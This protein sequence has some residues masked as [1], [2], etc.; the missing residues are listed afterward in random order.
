MKRAAL[1]IVVAATFL[2]LA[3][4]SLD[5]FTIEE[6]AQTTVEGAGVLGSALGAVSFTGFTGL[7]L[8]A[9][10]TLQNQGV[11]EQDIDSVFVRSLTLTVVSPDDGDFD[12]L[13]SIEFFVEAEGLD[14]VAIASGSNFADG[15]RVIGLDVSGVDLAPYVAA[16]SLDITTDATGRPPVEDTTIDAQIV[17]DVDVN[18]KGA[19]CGE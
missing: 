12:W 11:E 18:V 13:D 8:S 7:D 19:I 5:T 15:L 17:L 9:N 6:S 16:P 4:G 1:R 2:S 14:R 10:Q 3:C